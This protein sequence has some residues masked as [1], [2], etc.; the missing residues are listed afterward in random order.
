VAIKPKNTQDLFTESKNTQDLF[1][2]SILR[3]KIFT[4][5]KI[6]TPIE[7]LAKLKATFKM[8]QISISSLSLS[9][10]TIPSDAKHLDSKDLSSC[11]TL[12]SVCTST[13]IHTKPVD[14][15]IQENLLEDAF[16]ICNLS[17]L[18][19]QY[20]TWTDLL[21]RIKPYYG[22]SRVNDSCQM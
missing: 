13:Q 12:K 1:T 4:N 18:Q 20:K 15:L 7:N 17:S 11:Q 6:S 19:S 21:P 16:F 2:E 8:Q 3:S 22:T 10:P 5:K 9:L 14:V